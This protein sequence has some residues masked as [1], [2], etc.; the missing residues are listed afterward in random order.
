MQQAAG[1]Q[2]AGAAQKVQGLGS[3]LNAQTG[4]YGAQSASDSASQ[5]ATM[6]VVAAGIGAAAVIF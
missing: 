6:G 1:T 3:V 4:I 5:G 2:M